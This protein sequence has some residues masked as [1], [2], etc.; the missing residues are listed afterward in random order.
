MDFKD[1]CTKV[2]FGNYSNEQLNELIEAIKYRRSRLTA[3]K[4]MN[5]FPGLHVQFKSTKTGNTITGVVE[6]VNR[7]YTIVKTSDGSWRVPAVML[8]L[9]A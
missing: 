3:E 8:E 2:M 9:A 6:K 4:K 7:K 1:I 5:L